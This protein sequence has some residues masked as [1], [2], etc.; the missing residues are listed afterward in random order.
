MRCRVG[1]PVD[2]TGAQDGHAQSSG[3][4]GGGLAK[5]G[6]EP[7]SSRPGQEAGGVHV[8]ARLP[9]FSADALRVL[10]DSGKVARARL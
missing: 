2:G 8:R 4:W 10:R 1:V 6:R 3:G 9:E 7:L 5:G